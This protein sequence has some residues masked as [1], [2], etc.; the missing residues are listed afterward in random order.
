MLIII[1]AATDHLE[2]PQEW[3]LVPAE[4][5]GLRM[6]I[7]RCYQF[8]TI[9]SVA[10]I[11][12]RMVDFLGLILLKKAEK[13]ESKQDDQMVVFAVEAI[14]IIVIV[15]TVFII[16]G[17][18]MNVNVGSLVAGLGIGGLAFAL[19][20]KESLE[21]L[22]SS[23]IIFFDKPFEVGDSITVG[24]VSGTVEKV[25]FRSTRIR[26]VEKSL[27]TLPNRK[28]VDAE[29]DN[30][31][32][33]TL[34]RVRFIIGIQYQTPEE[35]INKIVSDI[36][37]YLDEHPQTNQENTV[38]FFEFGESSL[39]I[40]IQYFVTTI[41]WNITMKVREEINLKIS[42]VVK[43]NESNFAFPTRTIIMEKP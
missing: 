29:L 6:I 2:F 36:K 3:N 28:M 34:T 14:K 15:F 11:L 20:A 22:L 39:N 13:T 31:T 33:K 16:L 42:A 43:N 4:K 32:L 5:F 1:Y 10:W 41:D 27:V 30:L 17:S 26:T 19:A 18:V 38:R 25:G 7:E 12:L 37:K 35:K 40:L 9:C 23:F 8:V 21:N 24:N